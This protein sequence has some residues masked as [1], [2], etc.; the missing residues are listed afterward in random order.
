MAT[1]FTRNLRLKIDSNL[2]ANAKYNLERIDTLGSTFLVDST[3]TLKVRSKTNILIEPQSADLGG[4]SAPG[5]T[6][7]IGSSGFDIDLLSINAEQT[8]VS[9][10]IGLKNQTGGTTYG[11]LKYNS[12]SDSLDRTFTFDLQGAD[13][14]LSLGGNLTFAGGNLAFTLTGD[15]AVTLPLTGTLATLSNPEILTNKVIDDDNN[16]LQNIALTSLKTLFADADK[17]LLRDGLGAVVSQKIKNVHIA[18][19]A[20]ILDSKLATIASSGKV[21]NSATTATQ[22]NTPNAIVARD[23]SGN[24][25]AGTITADL[26]GNA[27]TASFASVAASFTGP[28]A[29]DVTGV[30]SGTVVSFVN[31]IPAAQVAAGVNLANNAT[32]LNTGLTLVRRDSLGNFSAGTITANLIGTATNVTGIVGLANGGTGAATAQGARNNIL[33]SQT[34]NTGKVLVTDSNNASWGLVT[35]DALGDAS[36]SRGKLSAGSADHVLINDGSGLVVSEAQLALT[37]GGTGAG[38][39]IGARTNILP[40]QAG[41]VDKFLRTDGTDVYWSAAAGGGGA[42]YIDLWLTADGTTKTVTHNLGTEN[43]SVSMIDL[44]DDTII[45]IDSI[46]VTDDNTLT[47]S[48]SETPASSWRIV[49]QGF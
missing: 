2:T 29:G 17:V 41:Q 11:F 27:S 36:I 49:V 48:A 31:G 23:S 28:L 16:T 40:S 45:G 5:G 20:A 24:F 32:N 39:A 33:P 19:D 9:Y 46:V 8:K 25:S 22:N 7:S 30:Q 21:L 13:R 18:D 37:R 42:T 44:D 34:A 4:T 26:S 10:P 3:D 6:V 12:S 35:N 15:T 47:L 1:S 38:S 14:T 43:V